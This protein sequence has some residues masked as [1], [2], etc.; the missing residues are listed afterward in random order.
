MN[1]QN[2]DNLF[3]LLNQYNENIFF[4]DENRLHENVIQ[5]ALEIDKNPKKEADRKYLL[6]IFDKRKFY[7]NEAINIGL[8]TLST[9]MDE[10]IPQEWDLYGIIPFLKNAGVLNKI[11]SQLSNIFRNNKF[12][13]RAREYAFS[14]WWEID[15]KGNIQATIDDYKTL[16]QNVQLEG[17]IATVATYWK[18]SIIEELK[19]L[20]EDD[21]G[22]KAKLIIQRAKEKEEEKKQKESDEKQQVIKKQ[23]SNADLIEKISELR[24]KINDNTQSN[25]DIGFK[26]FLPNES[27]FLQ[28]KT[29]N[30]DATL[31]KACISMREI[32]Q[33]LNEELGKHNLTNEEIKKLLP[34]TAEEDFNK[35][36]NKLFLFLK[37]KKFT[38]DPTIFGL[39]KLNQLAGLLGA[40]PRSEKDSLMQKLADVNLAKFYQEEDWGRL[41]QCLL[42][43]YEK[44][45]SALLSSL[46]S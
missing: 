46:K 9:Y 4:C 38:I 36:L 3:N 7:K 2:L 21:G 19:K 17:I 13:N 29:A 18:G 44:S 22:I 35:S 23:Y 1:R 15:P 8:K 5:I 31:I 43:M 16:K 40:H 14:K 28:L 39:R 6:Y 34:N 25:T 30:D 42:E 24:E 10:E 26:I 11:E 41:H 45:L 20:I 12:S 33:N 27:L 32:I 37:S